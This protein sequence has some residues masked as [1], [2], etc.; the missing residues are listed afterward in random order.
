M[1]KPFHKKGVSL[2]NEIVELV[3]GTCAT[4]E[5]AFQ[6]GQP[7]PAPLTQNAS[8][9]ALTFYKP[10]INS[11]LLEMSH[12][13]G[14]TLDRELKS[15]SPQDTAI[16]TQKSSFYKHEIESFQSTVSNPS[17]Y[18]YVDVLTST[19]MMKA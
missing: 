4:G 7:T 1:A 12:K 3:D 9:L 17:Y 6:A 19:R 11:E 18:I 14:R 5:N 10:I 15:D 13:G 8:T 2:F 16:N